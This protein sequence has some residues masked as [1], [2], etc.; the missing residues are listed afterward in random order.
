MQICTAAA[1]ASG[2]AFGQ[3]AHDRRKRF[4][5]QISERVR[6][7]N[8]FEQLVFRPF[9]RGDGRDN[10]L[11]E[12]VK[13]LFRNLQMIEFAAPHGVEKRGAFNQLIARERKDSAFRKA[14]NRMI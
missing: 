9:L 2:E 13:R 10:L 3:H 8:H 6:T 5:R 4:A 1:A 12:N 14:A 7:P 11:R